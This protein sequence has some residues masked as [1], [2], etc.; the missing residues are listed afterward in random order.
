MSAVVLFAFIL[1]FA[2]FTGPDRQLQK[3]YL[4][5]IM[6]LSLIIPFNMLIFLSSNYKNGEDI[7]SI[8]APFKVH[9]LIYWLIGMFLAEAIYLIKK[10]WKSDI[11]TGDV[12]TYG[13]CITIIAFNMFG[14]T[15][16]IITTDLH[17]PFENII[18]YSQIF[19]FG[20]KA[21]DEYI[22]VSGMY[23]VVQGFFLSFFGRGEVSFYYLTENLFYLFVILM[24]VP[25]LKAQIKGEWLLFISCCVPF[26]RYNRVALIVPI[27][28][29]LAWPKLIE[30]K[31][32][33]LKAWYLTSFVHGLYY[34]VYGAALCLGFLPLGIYQ[35]YKYAQTGELKRDVK[36]ISFWFWWIVCSIPVLAGSKLLLGTLK[37]MKAMGGQTVYADGITRFGQTVPGNFFSYLQS[38]PVRLIIYYLFSYLILISLVWVSAALCLRLGDIRVE[39]K[40]ISIGNPEAGFIALSIGIALLVAF[41]FTVI[42][43][44]TNSIYARSWGLVCAAFVMLI[45]VVDRYMSHQKNKFWVFAFAVF[46]IAAV[47]GEGFFSMGSA[48]KLSAYYTVPEGYKYVVNDPVRRLG[49]GFIEQNEYDS[50]ENTYNSAALS[51]RNKSYLGAGSFGVFYLCDL[52]GD[53]T[54]EIGTIKGFGAAQEAADLL[55]KNE[56]VVG[57]GFSSVNNYYLYRWLIMSGEYIWQPDTRTFIPNEENIGVDEIRLQNQF[58]D[59]ASENASLGRIAGSFGNSMESLSSIFGDLKMDYSVE[60]VENGVNI[61]FAQEVSGENADFVYID[62]DGME[63]NYQYI[64][65][66]GMNGAEYIMQDTE[67]FFKC[68]MKKDYNRDILVEVSWTDDN[69]TAH[70]MNC[71]MEKGK[72]LLPLGGGR[73][74]L[75]N[76]HSNI[77]VTVKQGENIISVPKVNEVRLLKL[78]EVQ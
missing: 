54:M 49:E 71:R 39:K 24:I 68:L 5:G 33:W 9:W 6:I 52:K 65:N 35:I 74:W 64:L 78:R 51:D 47:S 38:M 26:Y 23:S 15:G 42:R 41:S 45:L 70:A 63:D 60:T 12:V 18:G 3:D 50:I 32:L 27:M 1:S 21:F 17:H 36:K 14:G 8:H 20:Q 10:K 4:H 46:I 58:I 30:K 72:L 40:K 37:H 44:D 2:P 77:H 66:N 55:R 13:T 34:P 75:L 48:E 29:L 11:K 76:R 19:E 31:N 43:M 73:G 16:S 28:L 25:L 56:T 62:L 53:A 69:G 7:V 61:N 59:L 22:P 57:S 67:A